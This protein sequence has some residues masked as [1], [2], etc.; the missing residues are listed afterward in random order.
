MAAELASTIGGARRAAGLSQAELARRAGISASYLSRIEGAAWERGGP[1]PADAVLRA[2]AR[3]L[4]RSSTELIDL[5]DRAR[6]HGSPKAPARGAARSPYAVVVG[7]DMV[8]AAA[9]RL[10]ER[11]PPG[12]T[13]RSAQVLATG[14]AA[15]AS[16][17]DTLGAVA[18]GDPEAMLY[19]VCVVDRRRL[20]L[21]R[22]SLERS[23]GGRDPQEAG[24]VRARVT[25][26]SPLGMDLLIGD[27]EVLIGIP[28]RRGHP[29][30]RAAIVVD[31]PDFVAAARAWFDES[32]WDGPG[33]TVDL[34][35]RSLEDGLT[36]LRRRSG[37]EQH[38]HPAR[39]VG[40][41]PGAE[42]DLGEPG[43]EDVV[44][45]GG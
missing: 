25:T 27:R 40:V 30:L 34:R 35:R 45:M 4:G 19:R 24:N 36:A 32:V 18:A 44:A 37:A 13:L 26:T 21:V 12:G 17:V 3:A 7:A 33:P 43:G 42:A 9:R 38:L 41:G 20:D 14:D 23:A 16:Y 10:A 22:T 5:R 6:Q 39:P 31:D 2:L 28:D 8:D 15:A 1:W 11:N 29:H